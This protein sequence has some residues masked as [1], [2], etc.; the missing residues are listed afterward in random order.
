MKQLLTQIF[1]ACAALT[2]SASAALAAD[3]WGDNLDKAQA[4]ARAE[5]KLLLLDF[6]GSDWCPWCIKLDNEVFSQ[7]GFKDYAAKNLVLL[8]VDFP[9]TKPQSGALKAQNTRLQSKYKIQGYPTVIVLNSQGDKV[10]E[11]GYQPGGPQAFIAELEKLK[12]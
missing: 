9:Q 11:L 3:G 10:G 1:A 2:L 12:K 7:A 4:Q 5:K 6:T 8:E